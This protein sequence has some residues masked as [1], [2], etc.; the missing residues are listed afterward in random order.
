MPSIRSDSIAVA[1]RSVSQSC[2][3][4]VFLASNGSEERGNIDKTTVEVVSLKL[5][6]QAIFLGDE[7]NVHT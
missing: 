6:I 5:L 2:P 3:Q 1:T 4:V 7:L